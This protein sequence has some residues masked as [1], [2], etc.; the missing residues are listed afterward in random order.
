MKNKIIIL[1][2]AILTGSVL[3]G[4]NND[5]KSVTDVL[6]SAVSERAYTTVPVTDQQL[7]IILKSG[8]KS[9]SS[10]NRQPWKF[11]VIR[12]ETSVKEIINDAVA[13]NVLIVISGA[14]TPNG[15][16]RFDAGLTT[17][18]MFIAAHGLGLGARI[19]G[20]PVKTVTSNRD[21]YQIPA[22]FTPVMVLRVGNVNVDAV[23]SASPRKTF[24][25]VVNFKK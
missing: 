25:E 3:Y 24:D 2:I 23:S 5:K 11:T 20:S 12:D 9:P 6:L 16:D 1:T 4:Q 18:A 8:I 13:G 15:P 19:Y 17:E 10:S 21:Q 14:D 7:D 22:G